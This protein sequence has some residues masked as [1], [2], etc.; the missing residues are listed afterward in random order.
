ML[1]RFISPWPAVGPN[2]HQAYCARVRLSK[3]FANQYKIG[4]SHVAVFR[5]SVAG[6]RPKKKRGTVVQCS[7][8]LI[9]RHVIWNPDVSGALLEQKPQKSS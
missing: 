1:I 6:G 7:A 9:S 3:P 4:I 5:F 2:T 8:G